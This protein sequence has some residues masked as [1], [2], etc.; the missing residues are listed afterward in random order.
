MSGPHPYDQLV[1]AGWYPDTLKLA[2]QTGF[3]CQYCGMDFFESVDNYYS[4]QVEHII[5]KCK[6]GDDNPENLT[7]ACELC[8]FIKLKWDPR[9]FADQNAS[10]SELITAAREHISKVRRE[11]E[12]KV[13]RE[14]E[15]A[16][17]ICTERERRRR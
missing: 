8:N 14:R 2:I 13:A 1:S 4:L 16:R 3:R 17:E 7:V 12:A 10:R 11:R 5:P 15:M 6:G 9:S